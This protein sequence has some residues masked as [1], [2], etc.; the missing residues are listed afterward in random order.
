ME[1]KII[2]Y[3]KDEVIKE[4]NRLIA[5]SSGRYSPA[6]DRGIERGQGREYFTATI[7]LL[8]KLELQKRDK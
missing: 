6:F 2:S 8:S 3:D 4:A 7:H 5:G 1:I